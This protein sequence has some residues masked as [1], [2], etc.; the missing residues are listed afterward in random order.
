MRIKIVAVSVI[1]ILGIASGIYAQNAVKSSEDYQRNLRV[2]ARS[3]K[4]NDVET[5]T[6]ALYN[7]VVM[8]PRNDTL[9]ISLARLYFDA[10]K[11][12]PSIL[13]AN[14]VL[15]INPDNIAALEI[16]AIAK[17][18]I[19]ATEKALEDF[20]SLYL[21]TEDLNTLYKIGFLQYELQKF[22]EAA[23][24]SDILLAK[25][26]VKQIQLYFPKEDQSQQEVSMEA[27]LY[28]LKGLINKEKGEKEKAEENFEKALELEPDF[29]LAQKNMEALKEEE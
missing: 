4:Y 7:L 10:Q 5:A 25:D 13:V 12:I 11:F 21:K 16:S 23:T 2:Y 6:N 17:E 18:N 1:L 15:S 20:E 14:D 19:G 26:T 9:L 24:T 27:S 29:F 8:Q 3:M 22:T 28:N